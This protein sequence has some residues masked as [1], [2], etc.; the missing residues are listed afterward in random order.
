[1]KKFN[2]KFFNLKNQMVG[3]YFCFGQTMLSKDI[4]QLVFLELDHGHDMLN[5]SEID[6]KC[7]KVFRQQIAI[8]YLHPVKNSKHIMMMN[9]HGQKHGLYRRWYEKCLTNENNY[10]QGQRH[11]TT[12]GWSLLGDLL[13][14]EIYHHG[15]LK[16]KPLP[17]ISV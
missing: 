14:H 13:S 11:G 12:R 16:E 9:R 2:G 17:R 6:R 4:L 7:N 15:I 10:H 8:V 3:I 1:M 5:F